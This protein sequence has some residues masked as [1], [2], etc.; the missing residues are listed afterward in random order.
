MTRIGVI[1]AELLTPVVSTVETRSG[2]QS[3]AHPDQLRIHLLDNVGTK[4]IRNVWVT[5]EPEPGAS[6][7]NASQ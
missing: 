2:A 5:A 7:N 6:V 3:L 4:N 1:G